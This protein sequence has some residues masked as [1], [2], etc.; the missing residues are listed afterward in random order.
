MKC[1]LCMKPIANGAKTVVVW[2]CT[3]RTLVMDSISWFVLKQ[4]HDQKNAAKPFSFHAPMCQVSSG[5]GQL[6]VCQLSYG[7]TNIFTHYH[8][9]HYYTCMYVHSIC[10]IKVQFSW[11]H[12][13]VCMH[14]MGYG[15]TNS[16]VVIIINSQSQKFTSPVTI[17]TL[18]KSR[19][20]T[21]IISACAFHVVCERSVIGNGCQFEFS[22]HVVTTIIFLKL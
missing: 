15:P 4:V 2:R 3:K 19:Y 20:Y 14:H 7:A 10:R 16:S 1:A 5:H 22:I 11:I 13:G 6:A 8:V 12:V 9:P 21:A 17:I 18:K